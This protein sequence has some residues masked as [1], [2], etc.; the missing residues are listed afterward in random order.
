MP[1]ASLSHLDQRPKVSFGVRDFD[2]TFKLMDQEDCLEVRVKE[3][4]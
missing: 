1:V 3:E 2:S 4:A